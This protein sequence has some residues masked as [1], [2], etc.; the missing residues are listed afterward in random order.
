MK[1]IYACL[2]SCMMVINGSFVT[3]VAENAEPQTDEPVQE[4]Q[5]EQQEEAVPEEGAPAAEEEASAEEPAE[6]TPAEEVGETPA[7]TEETV[8]PDVA[9]EPAVEEP[10]EETTDNEPAEAV[11]EEPEVKEVEPAAEAAEVAEP[12]TEPETTEVEETPEETP[13]EEV[14][15]EAVEEELEEVEDVV[16]EVTEDTSELLAETEGDFQYYDNYDGTVYV[17]EYIG[18]ATEVTIPATLGGRTVTEI[19]SSA[20]ANNT[21]LKKVVIGTNITRI[22]NSAFSGCVNLRSINIPSSILS[23]GGSVFSGCTNLKT[24]GPVGSGTNIEFEELPHFATGYIYEDQVNPVFET[25]ESVQIPS[26]RVLGSFVFAGA[27]KLKSITIPDSVT[28]IR[29]NAFS[30]CTSLKSVTIP[31]SVTKVGYG[32]FKGCTS[33]TNVKLPNS[34]DSINQMFKGCTSLNKIVIP[35][36]ITSFRSAFSDCTSLTD[37]TLPNNLSRIDSYAFQGCVNLEQITIPDSV[38]YIYNEAFSGCTKLKKIDAKGVYGIYSKAFLNCSAL[39]EVNCPNLTSI[40]ENAFEN[41]TALKSVSYFKGSTI[42]PY[43]FYNCKNLKSIMIDNKLKTV[44]SGAFRDVPGPLTVTFHGTPDDWKSIEIKSYNDAL[45]KATVIY[46]I[47]VTEIKYPDTNSVMVTVNHTVKLTPVVSPSNA[48]DKSVTYTVDDPKVASVDQNG[49]VKGL[50]EGY[51][52]V[53][54][55]TTDGNFTAWKSIDVKD[56]HCEWYSERNKEGVWKDYWYENNERQAVPG[57]P[58]NLID[59]KFHVERGREIC[60]MNSKAWYWLDSAYGGAK[61]EGKEVWMPYIY[62]DEKNWKN[63]TAKMNEIVQAI[64]SY[65]ENGGPTSDMGEQVRKAILERTG[66]WVRYDSSGRMLKGWVTIEGNLA[67]LYP[68]Q[69]GYRYFYDYTTGLMAKGWTT[70]GGRRYY[71]HET[72]GVLLQEE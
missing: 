11:T 67:K 14:V 47:P 70:I 18:N 59:E 62:Q 58:K 22:E 31:S 20:F 45:S 29:D 48:A 6:E 39:T 35:N 13:S 5:P 54:V 65:S 32:L 68:D 10:A 64:N 23:V 57:D 33:L 69:A 9:E 19:G 40:E 60:D 66:K 24:A 53:K 4:V 51:T 1:K 16:E 17:S 49:N 27:S 26:V 63:D 28:E 46:K 44:E 41:C 7:G 36:S 72:T 3:V 61:A 30:Y 43:A 38:G 37:V 71:F 56:L 52:N 25:V 42:Q 15:E 55:Q 21:R 50:K 12:E 8:A 34:F 2:L